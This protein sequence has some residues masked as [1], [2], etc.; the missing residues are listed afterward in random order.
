MPLQRKPHWATREYHDFLLARAREPFDWGTNDCA[1]FAADGVLAI[2]GVDIMTELRGYTTNTGAMQKIHDVTSGTSF[3][4]AVVW[5]AGR[6]GL[7]E[8]MFPLMAQRGDL[9]LYRNADDSIAAGLVSLAGR[10]V[11]SPGDAGLLCM[12]LTSVHRAW[13]Y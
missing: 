12:P 3:E 10:E 13:T 11:V 9:V 8:R 1:T 7:I 6:H 2:T 4:E 5:C